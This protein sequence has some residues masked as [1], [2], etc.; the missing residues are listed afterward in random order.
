MKKAI[1]LYLF[2][3]LNVFGFSQ[4]CTISGTIENEKGEPIPYSSIYISKL[5]TGKMANMDG[6]YKMNLPCGKY[7]VKVQ[8][9]GYQTM[10]I[11]IDASSS[12]SK[13]IVLPTKSFVI[14]EVS[15]SA[16]DEDPA[17]N[18]MR[19]AIVMAKYYKKQLQEYDAK[20][21]IRFF[22]FADNVPKLAKLFADEK[23]L[24][25]L[26]AG[27]LSE[28]LIQYNYKRPNTV[29]EKIISTRNAKGDTSKGRLTSN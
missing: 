1:L 8:S 26:A 29:R 16:S 28:T 3:L 21:Y 17:Y 22:Y 27:D 6:K 10:F 15:V 13:T 23:D 14:K 4:T 2:V 7:K 11:E 18:V 19:K 9:L 12:K 25:E 24:K 5:A 20:I